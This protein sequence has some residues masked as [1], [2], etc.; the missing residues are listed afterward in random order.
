VQCLLQLIE[1]KAGHIAIDGADI[2]KLGH[3]K[4]R[5]CVSVI[6]QIPM[7]YGGFSLRKNLDPFHHHNEKQIN[8]ALLDVHM[9]YAVQLLSHGL[10]TTVT[11]GG[12]NFR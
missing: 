3:H 10:D 7:L 1:A 8:K 12:L 4:L 6:P 9:L 5:T 11:G 2:S